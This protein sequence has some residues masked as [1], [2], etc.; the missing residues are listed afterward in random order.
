ME[1]EFEAKEI[2]GFRT[3]GTL[4]KPKGTVKATGCSKCTGSEM[5]GSEEAERREKVTI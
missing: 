5:M 2:D 1:L 4:G 3:S